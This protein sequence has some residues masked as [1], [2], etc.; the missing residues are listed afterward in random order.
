MASLQVNDLSTNARH[1]VFQPDSPQVTCVTFWN[2]PLEMPSKDVDV[3]L[4]K[5]GTIKHSFR[6]RKMLRARNVHTGTS[7]FFFELK[8]PVPRSLNI[9]GKHVKS[10]YTGQLTH[11]AEDRADT[12]RVRSEHKKQLEQVALTR[13][14]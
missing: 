4:Q 1:V 13:V 5:C 14:E 12:E 3:V 2:I 8:S 7:V 11:M 10:K 6:S 9:G